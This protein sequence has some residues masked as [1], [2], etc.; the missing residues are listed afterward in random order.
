MRSFLTILL[1][2]LCLCWQSLAQAGSAVALAEAAERDHAAMHFHGEAHHHDE[3]GSGDIHQDE[4]PTSLQ[5][6]LDDACT[7]APAL[8]ASTSVA[9]VSPAR[10][11][12]TVMVAASVPSPFVDGLERPPRLH[13]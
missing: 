12:L 9:V 4:S 11:A 3:H 6:L 5:H 13:A 8:V 2:I 1:L 10:D 7:N